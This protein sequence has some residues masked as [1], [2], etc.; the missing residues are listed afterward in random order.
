ML[1]RRSASATQNS[2]VSSENSWNS[3]PQKTPCYCPS[4]LT[5]TPSSLEA[6]ARPRVCVLPAHG[7]TALQCG[8]CAHA[9][10]CVCGAD[11]AS[12]GRV[13]AT[14]RARAACKRG[15]ALRETER[16]GA[17]ARAVCVIGSTH[18][19]MPAGQCDAPGRTTGKVIR[20]PRTPAVKIRFSNE[21]VFKSSRQIGLLQPI[22][23][24]YLTMCRRLWNQGL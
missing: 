8:V 22:S 14:V 6:L 2:A 12:S 9:M 20:D 24:I 18:T 23:N 17:P 3:P 15:S 5:T 4:R 21:R 1:P 11:S 16:H 10:A 13:C 7:W 19:R